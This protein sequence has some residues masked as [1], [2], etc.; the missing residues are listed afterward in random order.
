MSASIILGILSASF[1]VWLLSKRQQERIDGLDSVAT[2][3]ARTNKSSTLGAARSVMAWSFFSA[4]TRPLLTDQ[5]VFD[6]AASSTLGATSTLK[7]SS[8]LSTASTAKMGDGSASGAPSLHISFDNPNW[9]YGDD[10]H[11]QLHPSGPPAAKPTSTLSPG[12]ARTG[13][14]LGSAI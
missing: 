2:R 8:M 13:T 10:H 1:T 12:G 3:C 5:V 11:V 7:L 6:Q 14:L 4:A 9:V